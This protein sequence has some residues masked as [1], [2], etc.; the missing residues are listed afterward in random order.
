MVSTSVSNGKMQG[1]IVVAAA[2]V[3]VR[4]T[5]QIIIVFVAGTVSIIY[6]VA[7]YTA[8][9]ARS[10]SGRNACAGADAVY[11]D[12]Y[13]YNSMVRVMFTLLLTGLTAAAAICVTAGRMTMATRRAGVS[14]TAATI[15]RAIAVA[16]VAALATIAAAIAV[17]SVVTTGATATATAAAGCSIAG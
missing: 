12:I 7:I 6:A 2:T 15:V 13:V 10:V 1:K 9:T 4:S 17:V 3:A 16:A 11:A 14:T 8:A 5:E